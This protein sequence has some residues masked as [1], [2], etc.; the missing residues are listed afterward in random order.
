MLFGCESSPIS[1]NLYISQS[2]S[3][4]KKCTQKNPEELRRTQKDQYGPVWSSKAQSAKTDWSSSFCSLTL[5]KL[6]V[7]SRNHKINIQEWQTRKR[8]VSLSSWLKISMTLLFRFHLENLEICP[9]NV[10][11]SPTST[12]LWAF[13][14]NNRC[15]KTYRISSV[16]HI[17]YATYVYELLDIYHFVSSYHSTLINNHVV[18]YYT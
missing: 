15:F 9:Q 2:V 11:P 5:L 8:Y 12:L 6:G 10:S 7:F 14:E 3:K 16:A 17:L 1:R 18:L 4:C 13:A